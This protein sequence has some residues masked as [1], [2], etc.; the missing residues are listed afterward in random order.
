MEKKDTNGKKNST[1]YVDAETMNTA[2]ACQKIC[3]IKSLNSYVEK[4]LEFYSGYLMDSRNDF[5]QFTKTASVI[6]SSVESAV[7]RLEKELALLRDEVTRLRRI[8]MYGAGLSERD[9]QMLGKDMP[10]NA[11]AD[12]QE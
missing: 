8:L 5:F 6:N 3:G 7:M 2:R 10:V 9:M 4:A 11:K 12:I 1:F